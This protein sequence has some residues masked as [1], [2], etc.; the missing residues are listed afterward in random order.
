MTEHHRYILAVHLRRLAAIETDIS[1]LDVRIEENMQA[2]QAQRAL[3]RR[4]PGVDDRIAC[5]IIA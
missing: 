3:L 4:I 1:T 2:F 5:N